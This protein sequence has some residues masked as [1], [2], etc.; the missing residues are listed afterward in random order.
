[1][2]RLVGGHGRAP[3]RFS[4]GSSHTTWA[5]AKQLCKYSQNHPAP[6]LGRMDLTAQGLSLNFPRTT[7]PK[8][9]FLLTKRAVPARTLDKLHVRKRTYPW[10]QE[11]AAIIE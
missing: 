10:S 8:P 6:H 4:R 7:L 2:G 3:G 9:P 11:E 1:M 5:A